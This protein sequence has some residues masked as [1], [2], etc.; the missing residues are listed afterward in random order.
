MPV[1]AASSSAKDFNHEQFADD[2]KRLTS[3]AFC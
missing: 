2:T 1:I 3:L